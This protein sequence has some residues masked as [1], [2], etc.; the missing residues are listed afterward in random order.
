MGDAVEDPS[1]RRKEDAPACVPSAHR[2]TPWLRGGM[3]FLFY[4][5]LALWAYRPLLA[6]LDDALIGAPKS[7]VLRNA[8]G[9]WWFKA[10]LIERFKLPSYT[11]YLNYPRGMTIL[12]IDPLNCLLSIPLQ[13]AFGMPAAF[14]LYLILS[15]AFAAFSACLLARYLTQSLAAAIPA[16]ALYAF[17][18]YVFSN[19]LSGNS[20]IVNIGWIPLFLLAFLKTLREG[21]WRYGLWTGIALICVTLSSW[22]YGYIVVLM[23]SLYAVGALGRRL[24][25][26]RPVKSALSGFALGAL[27]FSLFCIVMLILYRDII[28]GVRRNVVQSHQDLMTLLSGNAVNLWDVFRPTPERWDRPS[29]YHFPDEVLIGAVV[30]GIIGVRRSWP[31]IVLGF[32]SL[33]MAMAFKV[34][35]HPPELST[36]WW[37]L[38]SA[39]ESWS[40]SL[41]RAFLALPFSGVI[42]FPVRFIVLTNLCLAMMLAFG[43]RVL[44]VPRPRLNPLWVVV[45][46]ML[47]A[48]LT[49]RLEASARFREIFVSTPVVPPGYV[50]RLRADPRMVGVVHLPTDLGGGFQLYYQAIHEKPLLN[51]VDFVTA[52]VYY[53]E[54]RQLPLTVAD[55]IYAMQQRGYDAYLE[56]YPK[57]VP[58]WPTPS[59]IA[60]DFARL[61][62][63][64]VG[65]VVVHRDLFKA[66]SLKAFEERVGD[67]LERI[68]GTDDTDL[69]ALR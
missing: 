10:M 14:N 3:L 68:Q 59:R 64:G 38:W 26:R 33:L 43:L 51:Y 61:K 47:A 4:L 13:L 39:L 22:Y 54:G 53:L 8:W 9:F 50:E 29:L 21:G 58:P 24:V 31:W 5:L 46:A 60:E 40:S 20:E 57:D 36:M 30:A 6:V 63:M 27:V 1:A 15:V 25:R 42:R 37:P 19:A 34:Q 28:S 23:A 16:G 65:Y 35:W 44:L 69:Y 48:G 55:I 7:D 18:P 11:F 2:F 12:A 45:G 17:A 32:L 56:G 41:Y 67:H 52:R 49:H 62:K 66:E